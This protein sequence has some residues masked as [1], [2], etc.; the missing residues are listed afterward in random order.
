MPVFTEHHLASCTA[1]HSRVSALPPHPT[2][3]ASSPGHST[4]HLCSSSS[5]C[6]SVQSAVWLYFYMLVRSPSLTVHHRQTIIPTQHNPLCCFQVIRWREWIPV[7]KP[8]L[9]TDNWKMTGQ[10]FVQG[11]S[12]LWLLRTSETNLSLARY[13]YHTTSHDRFIFFFNAA[14]RPG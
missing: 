2:R 14:G 1:E 6:S 12:D 8:T 13:M 10:C 11:L 4:G 7:I 3:P 5:V 9:L